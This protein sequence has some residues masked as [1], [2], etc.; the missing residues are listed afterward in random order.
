MA[1]NIGLYIRVST[2][3]QA[4]RMEGSLESQKHRLCGYVDI[5]NM[6]QQNWGV[7]VDEYIDD[8][9]SAKDTNRPALQK[10][11]KDLKKGRINTV[12]VT[13]LSRLSRSIRDF[14]VLIDFFKETKTQFLS[15]KEQFDTTTAA[16]EMM[17][18]NM[19][20]L[21]QFERRQIS[22]RVTLNETDLG[23]ALLF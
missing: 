4:L 7:V 20:N 16:G 3:E 13:D 5:K 22:E 6:Q 21:A 2:E 9:F 19:I 11:I 18:F 1:F 14:C 23:I 15:L 8:G 10:L 17:L 12:L